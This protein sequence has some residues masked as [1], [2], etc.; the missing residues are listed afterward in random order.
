MVPVE[1][2]TITRKIQA[3]E[4][5]I[6]LEIE[7]CLVSKRLSTYQLRFKSCPT[8]VDEVTGDR[9]HAGIR[10]GGHIGGPLGFPE[11]ILGGSVGTPGALWNERMVAESFGKAFAVRKNKS[12]ACLQW[13]MSANACVDC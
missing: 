13:I 9:K 3:F 2:S 1:A 8:H 5:S 11:L 10:A 7:N 6:D 12:T 4:P